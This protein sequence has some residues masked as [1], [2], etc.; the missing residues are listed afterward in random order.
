MRGVFR[1][2]RARKTVDVRKRR[3]AGRWAMKFDWY[4]IVGGS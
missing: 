1:A 3:V 2:E 4:P